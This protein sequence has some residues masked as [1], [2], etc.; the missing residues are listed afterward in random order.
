MRKCL[1]NSFAVLV[2]TLGSSASALADNVVYGLIPSYTYGA[3]TTSFDLDKVNASSTTEVAPG[4]TFADAKTIK[5][6]VTVG[7]KYYAFVEL[8]DPTTYD[9]TIALVTLNFTTGNMVV[10]NNFS[11]SYGKPG[12]NLSGM[13]YDE[14]NGIIYATEIGFNDND[15]YITTLYSLNPQDGSLTEV[16]NWTGQFNAIASDHNGG[17]YMLQNVQDDMYT[18]PNLYKVSPMF[19]ISKYVTNNSLSTGWS[20]YN[21]MVVTDD[22]KTAYL[23]ENKKV[24]AFDLEAKT[25][26]LKGNLSNN[27][28]SVSYGKSSADGESVTPPAEEKKAA[29]FLIETKTY[30]NSMGDIPVTVESAHKRYYYNTDGKQVAMANYGREY[31]DG[32]GV[33]DYFSPVNISKSTFDDNGNITHQD[34]Y[35]WGLYDYDEYAWKKTYNFYSYVYDEEGKLTSDTTSY[36]I[37]T[38]TYN[39]DGTLATDTRYSKRTKAKLQTITYSNY[40]TKGQAWHY[41]SDGAYDSYKYEADVAYDDNGNKVEEYTYNV[42]E[43]PD[44]P[45]ETTPKPKEVQTWTYEDNVLRLYTKNSFNDDGEEVPQQKTIYTPV[46]G[47]INVIAVA[48]STYSNGTWYAGDLP[49]HLIYG[50]FTDMAEMTAMEMSARPDETLPNTVDIDFSFPQLAMTQDCKVVVYRDCLPVDTVNIMDTYNEDTGMC[51]YQDKNIKNGSYSYFLQPLF[52]PSSELDPMDL[53][54]GNEEE[55]TWTGY[56]STNPVNVEVY[57]KL[58]AVK[59]LA[60]TSGKVETTGSVVNLRKTYYAGL[61]WENPDDADKYGFKKNSIYFVG[62]GVSELDTTD[63]AANKAEVM[64]YDDDADVYVVT[65]YQL[66][67]AIS[68]TIQVKLKDVQNLATGIGS[69]SVEGDVKATFNGTDIILADKANV[70]V[71]TADG[72][73][74]FAKDNTDNVT[75]ANL[76]TATYIICV[77]KNGK[78]SAY[79][80]NVK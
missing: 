4:F 19:G 5:C 31:K 7:D 41:S 35:Q 38:Y 25:V 55:V 58:P 68:D 23:V 72:Q 27:V 21:S 2:L 3:Q 80:Y 37:H 67:K 42:V 51:T 69:V 52:A 79:K 57:T 30:G 20:S 12:Y 44:F 59:N 16:T 11:Y 32:G 24:L 18:Y 49:K 78:V 29:R 34:E 65:S 71:F 56:Y 36:E 26:A 43:D 64:L 46:D 54:G 77:E 39:D 17:F 61:S 8:E 53:D 6:G 73:K 60:L 47:N 33:S 50:D 74:V 48:D 10:V 62:A 76:P 22:G 1:L 28:S 66:G 63:I 45:G 75:L 9:Q 13:A 15:E 14:K 70:S 40:D